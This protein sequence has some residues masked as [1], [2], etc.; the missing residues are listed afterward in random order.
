MNDEEIIASIA[1]TLTPTLGLKIR[2]R[3]I[4]RLESASTILSSKTTLKTLLPGIKEDLITSLFSRERKNRALEE[5]KFA[6]NHN[7]QCITYTDKR[8]PYRL[9]ECIDAPLVLYFKGNCDFNVPYVVSMVG[10]R[11]AT[12]YGKKLC[13][14]FINDL[15]L[16]IPDA[17]IISGLAFGID[18]ASHKASIEF[19]HPTVGVLAHGLDRIYPNQHKNIAEQMYNKGGILTEFPIHTEPERYNFVSRNRIIAGMS[20]ATIVIESANKGGALITADLAN[21][22]NRDCFAFPGRTTDQYSE[23]CNKIIRQNK[24][25]LITSTED[26]VKAMQWNCFNNKKCPIQRSLFP[27]LTPQEKELAL[28][29]QK[30]GSMQFDN[31]L[32]KTKIP[33]TQL[34]TLLFTLEMKGVI[35]ILTGDRY[36]LI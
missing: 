24:A 26:F 10:T 23:G 2:K 34:H 22:Y 13:H 17:L 9:K 11:K 12:Q 30:Q 35:R 6:L 27:D 5:Y 33:L 16:S 25:A 3:L 1:L 4:D 28:L 36:E 15:H 31:I 8:Y 32:L 21:D 20:D 14:D 7:I 29:L 18:I 19:N